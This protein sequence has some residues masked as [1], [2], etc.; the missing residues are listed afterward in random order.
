MLSALP[1]RG[2]EVALGPWKGMTEQDGKGP[3]SLAEEADRVGPQ[4]EGE[5]WEAAMRWL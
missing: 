5:A 1:L 3:M 2:P 4:P